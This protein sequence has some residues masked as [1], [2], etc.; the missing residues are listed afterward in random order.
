MVMADTMHDN[1]WLSLHREMER[2]N[3]HLRRLERRIMRA[4]VILPVAVSCGMLV[5]YLYH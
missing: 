4:M 3:R 2:R 5:W 1:E